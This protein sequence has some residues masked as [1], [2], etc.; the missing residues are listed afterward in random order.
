MSDKGCSPRVWI[1]LGTSWC[2]GNLNKIYPEDIE[3]ISLT[4]HMAALESIQHDMA[5]KH[6]TAVNELV[7]KIFLF[8]KYHDIDVEL[9]K[10]YKDKL[11]RIKQLLDQ[12]NIWNTSPRGM[13][14][15]KEIIELLS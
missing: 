12:L 5:N 3:Y 4:E 7:G 1:R 9:V 13:E 10:A 2:E 8:E 11:A 6:E 15:V 14:I